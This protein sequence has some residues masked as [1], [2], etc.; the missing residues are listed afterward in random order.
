[1]RRIEGTA[2]GPPPLGCGQQPVATLPFG[3]IEFRS[4]SNNRCRPVQSFLRAVMAAATQMNRRALEL[5]KFVEHE[6]IAVCGVSVYACAPSRRLNNES[7]CHLADP[8]AVMPKSANVTIP[9]G[10]FCI[11]GLPV[12]RNSPSSIRAV[13]AFTYVG[14]RRPPTPRWARTSRGCATSVRLYCAGQVGQK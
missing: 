5:E 11:F 6:F 7:F 9:L 2:K 1:V 13:L 8:L 4:M 3:L 14:K 12:P 10:Y